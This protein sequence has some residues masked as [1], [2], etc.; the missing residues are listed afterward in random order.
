MNTLTK[1]VVQGAAC[2]LMIGAVLLVGGLVWHPAT[3]A[4]VVRARRFEMV[5]TAGNVRARLEDFSGLGP[6]LALNDDKG[7]LRA[8]LGSGPGGSV[9]LRLRDAKGQGRAVL[10]L[11]SDGPTLSMRDPEGREQVG[12][13]TSSNGQSSLLMQDAAGKWR[14]TLGL[15]DGGMPHLTL[16]DAAGTARAVLGPTSLEAAK[17]GEIRTRPESS[18]VLFDKDGRVMWQAP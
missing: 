3:V 5:D 13:F 9:A 12:L 2:G 16:S 18:L 6:Q 17:T 1:A 15:D 14:A 8:T 7:Q 10:S 11:V 4:D